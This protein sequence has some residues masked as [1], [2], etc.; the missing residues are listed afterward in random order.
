MEPEKDINQ[1]DTSLIGQPVFGADRK[2]QD[3]TKKA[4]KLTAA[5]YLVVNFIPGNSPLKDKIQ[6][7]SVNFLTDIYNLSGAMFN[8][9][10]YHNTQAVMAARKVISFLSIATL[11]NIVSAMN[12]SILDAEYKNIIRALNAIEESPLLEG[13][14]TLRKDFFRESQVVGLEAPNQTSAVDKPVVDAPVAGEFREYKGQV[15]IKDK[16]SKGLS[17]INLK[18]SKGGVE[19]EHRPENIK[20]ERREVIIKLFRKR[21]NLSIKDLSLVIS[22]CS[23]KTIQR[24]LL[25]LVGQGIL[26]KE[27][28]K[29]WSR[30]ALTP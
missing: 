15:S 7:E 8:E 25:A 5:T 19:R 11:V 9:R 21:K 10:I 3:L 18:A 20:G 17:F 12:N 1:K 6:A 2:F 23:E 27:G 16:K 28:S 26:K 22:D 29:R 13:A 24:E 14:L 30:Y 4:E